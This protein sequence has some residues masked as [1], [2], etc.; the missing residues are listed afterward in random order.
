MTSLA[1][2]NKVALVTGATSG[3][4]QAIAG[5][6]SARG[7][8]VICC[9]L[10]DPE[11][12]VKSIKDMQGPHTPLY[13]QSDVSDAASIF[14]LFKQCE[15]K[16]GGIDIL[17]NNAGI[18]NVAKVED[19][20]AERWDAVIAV[21]LTAAFHT[22]RLAVPHMKK[23]RWGRIL[24]IASA[25]GLVG[26]PEKAPYVAAKHGLVGLT[27]AVALET[28]GTGVTCNAICPGWVRTPLVEAQIEANAQRAGIS[29]EAATKEL[30]RD[31]HPS[32]EFV[33]PDDIAEF[34]AFLCSPA[35]SQMTGAALSMDGGWV[36]R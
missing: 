19:T 36:A 9:G 32:E 8:R 27:K 6:L 34:C 30:L 22:T 17:V 4:G 21:N 15:S 28:A 26:S 18:Q 10:D 24:N 31:K 3:V 7:C 20:T 13:Y 12:G 33:A 25:H 23:V 14:Q 16:L 11:K 1:L 29:V 35:A 5:V 2:L